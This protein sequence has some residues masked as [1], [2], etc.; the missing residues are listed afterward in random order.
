MLTWDDLPREIRLLIFRTFCSDI[1][2]E[3]KCLSTS[4]WAE[5]TYLDNDAE[6]PLAWPATPAPLRSFMAAITSC[7]EFNH[8]IVHQVK[9]GGLS[10]IDLLKRQQKDS[11]LSCF[12]QS[13]STSRF[14]MPFFYEATGPFWKNDSIHTMAL[15]I[16]M[17][18]TPALS[19]RMLL[20]HV[21]PVL[22]S[23]FSCYASSE[24]LIS[25]RVRYSAADTEGGIQVWRHFDVNYRSECLYVIGKVESVLMGWPEEPSLAEED[26]RQ[27]PAEQWSLFLSVGDPESDLDWILMNYKEKRMYV[28]PD[29]SEALV[30]KGRDIYDLSTWARLTSID[31]I[32]E[33]AQS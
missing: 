18:F 2:D 15:C 32:R 19:R 28:G 1:I 30:W 14:H 24:P 33:Y 10:P 13:K 11:L 5:E 23:L 31:E 27:S 26:I 6:F 29:C 9:F 21:E 22:N 17:I 4:I 3:F 25:P 8:I 20:P 16:T 7:R 12:I